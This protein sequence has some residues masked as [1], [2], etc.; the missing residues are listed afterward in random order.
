MLRRRASRSMREVTKIQAES[1]GGELGVEVSGAATSSGVRSNPRRHPTGVRLALVSISDYEAGLF[2]EALDRLALEPVIGP[3]ASQG[4]GIISGTCLQVRM[5]RGELGRYE[6]AG[7][8]RLDPFKGLG[9][10]EALA[11][12]PG[13]FRRRLKRGG[14][15]FRAPSR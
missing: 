9:V 8:I 1:Q 13:E 2:L 6:D 10:P 14:F 4:C 12:M 3:C 15:D 11:T 5:R 7:E